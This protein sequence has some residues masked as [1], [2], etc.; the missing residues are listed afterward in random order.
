[1][2]LVLREEKGSKLTIQEMDGNL[3]YLESLGLV[4][5]NYLFV[6]ANGTPTENGVSLINSYNQAKTMSPSSN[7]I[8]NVVVPSGEYGFNG[9][10][11]LDTPY[12]NLV[13]LTGN[14]DVIFDRIDLLDPVVIDPETNDPS[15]IGI[16]LMIDTDYVHVKGIKGKLRPSETWTDWWGAGGSGYILPIQVGDSLPNITVEN[17]EGGVFSFGGDLTFGSNPITVSGTYIKCKTPPGPNL[18]YAFA[19][20]GVASGTFIDCEAGDASF[21]YA[22]LASGVFIN[23]VA[24]DYSFGDY[25]SGTFRNC[26]GGAEAFGRYPSGTYVDCEGGLYSFGGF[27]GNIA[28]GTFIRCTGNDAFGGSLTG[29]CY[30]CRLTA[31]TYPTVSGGGRTVY[32]IDGNNNTNNQ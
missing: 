9:T 8:I 4:G 24:G 31:G 28:S 29:K 15:E 7:N 3:R 23:C 13:S 12:I 14:S 19:S 18:G 21:A 16:C 10:F 22:N 6:P 25:S 27:S 17:C 32:C 30:Y 1:M 2:S 5:T 11:T 26:I 20:N